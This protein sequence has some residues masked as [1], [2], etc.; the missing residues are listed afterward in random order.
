MP[1]PLVIAAARMLAR[2][3]VFQ[4]IFGDDDEIGDEAAGLAKLAGKIKPPK[5]KIKAEN[6]EAIRR[7]YATVYPKR[8]ERS[9]AKL[10][11]RATFMVETTAKESIQ[12]GPHTGRMYG[13]HQASAPGE[14]P[15]TDTGFLVSH[16]FSEVT[17][18]KNP[19]GMV[20]STAP[21]S[22]HLEFGTTE[23]AARPYMF[24]AL[25]SNRA[26]IHKMFKNAGVM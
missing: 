2:K 5:L 19:S 16:I 3:A 12:Q 17:K 15:A 1:G 4:S 10:I 25:E 7:K 8:V 21:Y 26:K 23:M 20:I 18:G 11:A 24:P 6:A 9:T 14:A 13:R 22:S